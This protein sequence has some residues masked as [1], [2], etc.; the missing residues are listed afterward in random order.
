MSED[1]INVGRHHTEEMRSINRHLTERAF[2]MRCVTYLSQI[3]AQLLTETIYEIDSSKK[4]L[5]RFNQETIRQKEIIQRQKEELE[6]KNKELEEAKAALA[7]RFEESSEE[8]EKAM[9]KNAILQQQFLSAQKFECI[10]R[11]AGGLAHDFNNILSGIL[12]YCQ[13]AILNT[14]ET[15][16]LADDLKEIYGAGERAVGLVKKLLAVSRRQQLNLE[17]FDVNDVIKRI[18]SL[19]SRTIGDDIELVLDLESVPNIEADL[20]QL[21]QILLNLAVNARDAMKTGGKLIIEVTEAFL[22]E[23]YARRHSS[24]PG[25]HVQISFTDSGSGM[26]PEVLTKIFDPFYTT[27]EEGTGLGLAS[28]QGIVRQHKGIIHVYSEVGFGTTFKLYFPATEAKETHLEKSWSREMPRGDETVLVVDDEP[29]IRRLVHDT[30][31]PLGYRVFE[32]QDG[33]AALSD[34]NDDDIDILLSDVIM[35]QIYGLELSRKFN[36]HHPKTKVI[37]MSGY[38]EKALTERIEIDESIAFLSKPVTPS[39]LARLVRDVLDNH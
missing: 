12:G 26:P 8:L 22:E 34:F 2:K 7:L 35:P 9:A 1:L 13:L 11:L 31:H 19:L 33:N 21:E 3:K 4:S 18:S 28:V 14:P 20:G 37:L 24:F 15:G 36:V 25:R 30:L 29:T 16:Q 27:K 6:R 17:V 5:L 23:E 10:G 39:K 32:A 38:T